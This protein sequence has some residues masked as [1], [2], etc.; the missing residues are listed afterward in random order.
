MADRLLTGLIEYRDTLT[1]HVQQ[2]EQEFDSLNREWMRFD[3]IYEGD[4]AH[5]FKNLWMRTATNFR[6][7]VDRSRRILAVLEERIIFLQ[8][9]DRSSS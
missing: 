7:Y 3:A 9:A 4:A 2:L 8:E 6:E 5:E 1:K